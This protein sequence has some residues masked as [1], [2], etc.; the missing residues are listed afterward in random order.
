[1]LLRLMM[2]LLLLWLILLLLML[3]DNVGINHLIERHCSVSKRR[4]IGHLPK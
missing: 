1:M 3:N 4:L 2:M